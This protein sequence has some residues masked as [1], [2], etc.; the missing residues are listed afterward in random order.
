MKPLAL[1]VALTGAVTLA[2]C[3]GQAHPTSAGPSAH[4]TAS[5]SAVT[6]N[7]PAKYDAWAH[8]PARKLVATLKS[9]SSASKAPEIPAL[10]VALKKARPAVL[11]AGRYPIPPCAD[12]KGYWTALLMHVNAAVGNVG[13]PSTSAS[14]TLALKGVPEIERKLSTELKT[15]AGVK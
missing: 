1:A 15:T 9:V 13:T 3:S 12:P 10:T 11:A 14:V 5:N 6:I 7:C 8:G 4:A 2:A